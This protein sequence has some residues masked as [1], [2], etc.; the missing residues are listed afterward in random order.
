[1]AR[2]SSVTR[3]ASRPS[4]HSAL[5]RPPSSAQRPY[6][7]TEF[8]TS[9]V[10]VESGPAL[11]PGP[12]TRRRR[13]PRD[14]L[15]ARAS[16]GATPCER[17]PRPF[18]RL[19]GRASTPACPTPP[20]WRTQ[21]HV[22]KLANERIDERRRRIQN[23]CSGT[24]AART[25]PS[26]GHDA[27]SPWPRSVSATRATH[28][29]QGLLRAGDPVR[30]GGHRLGGERSGPR[31]LGHQDEA[32][33]LEWIDALADDLTDKMRP[34]EVRSFGRTLLAGAY[35]ITAWHPVTSPTAR[36]RR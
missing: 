25:T 20:W 33:A 21:F 14:W 22:V 8:V 30:P 28:K 18:R 17:D 6:Y 5:T 34:P 13:A 24:E 19:Q 15:M 4:T 23:E 1:M 7:R 16:S 10:D 12:W 11:G 36:P 9:I 31:A 32:L 27:C 3:A 35:E 26:I 2:P 29:M